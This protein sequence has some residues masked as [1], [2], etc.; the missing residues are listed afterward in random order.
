MNSQMLWKWES[1]HRFEE[2]G[3]E[4]R[5]GQFFLTMDNS[6]AQGDGDHCSIQVRI[7]DIYQLG[8]ALVEQSYMH[9]DG[10]YE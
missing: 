10:G 5:N 3:L 2:M 9:K 6:N 4:V 7:L 1:L 8:L